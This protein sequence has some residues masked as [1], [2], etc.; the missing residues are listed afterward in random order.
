MWIEPS[1]YNVHIGH[2]WTRAATTIRGWPGLGAGA[3]GAYFQQATRIN[4]GDRATPCANRV[5]VDGV[6]AH[7]KTAQLAES[8]LCR[9]TVTDETYIGGEK[10]G[11]RGRGA[12]HKCAVAIA[13]EDSG[14]VG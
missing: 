9:R 12:E 8:L 11:K 2:S 4:P 1:E 14:K 3:H 13:V 5:N 6:R 7:R 10:P